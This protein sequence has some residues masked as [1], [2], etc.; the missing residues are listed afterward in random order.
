[1]QATENVLSQGSAGT[2]GEFWL[3]DGTPLEIGVLDLNGET[4]SRYRARRIN[5]G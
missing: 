3:R 2:L 1:M 5:S 4:R